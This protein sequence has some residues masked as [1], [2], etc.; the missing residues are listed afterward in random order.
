MGSLRLP[1]L[2]L[3]VGLRTALGS[4]GLEGGDDV[5]PS[6][7]CT[8]CGNMLGKRVHTIPFQR[9]G[10]RICRACWMENRK[11]IQIQQRRQWIQSF[12]MKE[13]T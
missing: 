2:T 12:P 8:R 6:K 1:G 9:D 13:A 5:M 3:S 10:K 7:W 11:R 4:L